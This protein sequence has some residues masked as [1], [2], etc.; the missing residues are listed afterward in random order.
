[1]N[2]FETFGAELAHA[3]EVVSAGSGA[4]NIGRL[5]RPAGGLKLAGTGESPEDAYSLEKAWRD[6]ITQGQELLG[7]FNGLVSVLYPEVHQEYESFGTSPWLKPRKIETEPFTI[8]DIL[9]DRAGR[10]AIEG[11]LRYRRS[12][13]GSALTRVAATFQAVGG[14]AKRTRH[15]GTLEAETIPLELPAEMFDSQ[16]KPREPVVAGIQ[17]DYAHQQLMLHMIEILGSKS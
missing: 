6:T 13:P 14:T 9:P 15:V 4:V 17:H 7:A 16:R 2:R 3:Y 11:V 12:Y 8:T 5:V 10:T 1:M